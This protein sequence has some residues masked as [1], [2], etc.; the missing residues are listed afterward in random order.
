MAFNPS[1]GVFSGFEGVVTPD[2]L[3]QQRQLDRQRARA[4]RQTQKSGE[5]LFAAEAGAFAG[6]VLGDTLRKAFPQT[7]DP[8]GRR[9]AKAQE[10]ISEAEKRVQQASEEDGLNPFQTRLEA[11]KR[12]RARA[13]S[14]GLH[15]MADQLARNEIALETQSL[16]F[17]KLNADVRAAEQE[18]DPFPQLSQ[19]TAALDRAD[20]AGADGR[21]SEARFLRAKAA[22]DAGIGAEKVPDIIATVRQIGL[23]PASGEGRQLVLESLRGASK[24]SQRDQ[25]IT[26]LV[27]RG[28]PR[29]RAQDIVDGFAR[30]EVVPQTGRVRFVNEVDGTAFEVPVKAQP[31]AADIASDVEPSL[32]D[33]PRPTPQRGETLFDLAEVATG[34]LSAAQNMLAVPQ[35]WLGLEPNERVV[36]ARQA[37]KTETQSLVRSLAVNPRFPVAEMERIR[38]EVN[39]QPRIWDDPDLLRSRMAQIHDSLT[40]RMQQAAADAQDPSLPQEHREAQLTNAANIA[41]FLGVLGVDQAREDV[42]AAEEG[43]EPEEA[44]DGDVPRRIRFDAQGNRIQ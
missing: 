5:R 13:R 21:L 33:I 29:D 31:R 36:Q 17:R 4:I 2:V 42:A 19:I 32:G 18:Q 10:I 23:D 38:Q 44:A 39:I 40:L 14:E 7:L 35:A 28:V 27:A 43:E 26:D 37:L 15:D 1:D 8:R 9:A 6:R 41:N 16:E 30:L 20:R 3:D 34:P 25:K 22:K 11:V 12:A 24:A